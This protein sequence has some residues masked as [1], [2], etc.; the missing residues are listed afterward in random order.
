MQHCERFEVDVAG[1]LRRVDDPLRSGAPPAPA[2][3]AYLSP[4]SSR[5]PSLDL[6]LRSGSGSNPFRDPSL[7]LSARDPSFDSSFRSIHSASEA[8][9][10]SP[11][12][13][14]GDGSRPDP[15]ARRPSEVSRQLADA[16]TEDLPRV[17]EESSPPPRPPSSAKKEP[18]LW[19]QFRTGSGWFAPL[20]EPEP[21]LTREQRDA[22][23]RERID[24]LKE[25]RGSRRPG[26]MKRMSS[27]VEMG[28]ARSRSGSTST[29]RR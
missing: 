6:S 28:F 25:G 15:T 18:G 12:L 1:Q 27:G 14:L 23:E 11:P 9:T 16:F 5:G 8:S 2:I 22:A 3:P 10:H 13:P 17:S 7:D 4:A 19:S 20:V 29:I 24:K 26:L 21:A